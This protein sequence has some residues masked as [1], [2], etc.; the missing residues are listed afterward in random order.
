MRYHSILCRKLPVVYDTHMKTNY[1]LQ[2]NPRRKRL[3]MQVN[4]QGE[5]IVKAPVWIKHKHIEHFIAQNQ[6]WIRKQQVKPMRPTRSF[7][8]GSSHWLWGTSY[9]LHVEPGQ[10]DILIKAQHHWYLTTVQPYEIK[11]GQRLFQ[12]WL[13]KEANQVFPEHVAQIHAQLATALK[14]PDYQGV[15]IRQMTTRWGSCSSKGN[16]SL[17]LNLI[18]FPIECLDYIIVHELCHLREMNHSAKFYALMDQGMPH[19]RE[20][21]QQL[22]QH[23]QTIPLV[24]SDAS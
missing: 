3:A 6:A 8:P 9:P 17:A 22:L 11:T 21:K 20:V 19:W 13:R 15:T 24:D 14:L 1:I 2:T 10:K 12:R 18:Y 4:A 5:L 7:E 23:A 16:I